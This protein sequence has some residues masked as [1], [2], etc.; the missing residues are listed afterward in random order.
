MS[1]RTHVLLLD[2]FVFSEPSELGALAYP[3]TLEDTLR[4]THS[5]SEVGVGVYPNLE[6]ASQWPQTTHGSLSNK[7]YITVTAHDHFQYN[8]QYVNSFGNS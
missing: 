7:R 6:L 8:I 1:S 2:A 5:G 4:Q 3:Q